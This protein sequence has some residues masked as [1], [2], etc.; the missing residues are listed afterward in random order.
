LSDASD[1]TGVGLPDRCGDGL[2]TAV[3]IKID[4]EAFYHTCSAFKMIASSAA[5]LASV[6][7]M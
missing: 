6:Y 4:G 1:G 2:N 7:L 5:A 3:D